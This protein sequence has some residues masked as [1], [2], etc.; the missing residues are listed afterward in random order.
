MRRQVL[1]NKD[2][3][4]F[5]PKPGEETLLGS[6]RVAARD[7]AEGRVTVCDNG[8]SIAPRE[9]GGLA[10]QDGIGFDI[11]IETEAAVTFDLEMGEDGGEGGEE[12]GK[13]V[14]QRGQ[15]RAP[16]G[17]FPEARAHVVLLEWKKE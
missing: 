6:G 15:R 14:D 3:T 13:V 10:V 11:K 12:D 2:D 1:V 4:T 5:L 9:A 16:S 8:I 17:Q 7:R